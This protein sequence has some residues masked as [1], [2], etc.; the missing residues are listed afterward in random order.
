MKIKFDEQQ[1]QLDAVN[2]IVDIFDG[3]PVKV[4]NFSVGAGHILG[5]QQTELGI[6]NKLELS[7]QEILEN[8]QTIQMRNHLKKS[9]AIQDW[10]FTVEM[11]TGTGKTYVYTRSIFELNKKY[12]F[13]KFIIV[14]PSVAIREGVYK[15]FQMTADHFNELYPGQHCHYF[16]YDSSKL[17]KVREFAT[18]SDI[19]VMIINIDAFRKSFDDPEKETKAN[20][21]HRERDTMNGKKPIEFIQETNPIV[22]I[23]EPQSVDNTE[24]AKE[25]I[26]SLNPLCKLRYSAT[27]RETYNL[28]YKLDPIDAYDQRLVKK[29]EVLSVNSDD[30]YNDPYIKLI[31]VS[32]KSGYKATIEL[33]EKK[34]N[35]NVTRVRKQI[36]PNKKNNLFLLS[37]ERDLYQGY[38]VDGIDCFPGNESIEFENGKVL[39]LGGVIGGMDDNLLKRYQ[40]RETIRTHLDK[41]LKLVH[42]GIKVLSLF[43]ID[44]VAN[45]RIYNDD[46]TWSHGR[47]AQMFEEEYMNLIKHQKYHA[48]FKEDSFLTNFN[49]EDVHGGYFSQD[50]KGN[51]KDSRTTKDGSLRSNKDDESFF[52][53]IM[54]NKE[55][56]LSFEEPT[57]FIFSHSALKEGWDNPNVFQICTLVETKDTLTK[58]QKIGRGLRLPV[59]K[60][61]RRVYDENDNILTV[62]A[63]ESYEEFADSLQK[64]MED[65]TGIKFGYIEQQAFAPI[66]F[67]DENNEEQILGYKKSEKLFDYLLEKKYIDKKGKVKDS[68][69]QDLVSEDF[70]VPDEF[71]PVQQEIERVIKKSIKKLPVFNEKDKVSIGLN[72]EVLLSEDFNQLWDKI[73]YKTTYSVQLDSE[74]LMNESVSAI[75]KL[76]PFR[77]RKVKR[78]NALLKVEH[79]GVTGEGQTLRVYEALE[80]DRRLPDILRYLQEQT[81][82]KRRT[83]VDI[84]IKSERLD[85]F[86]RDPQ[87]FMEAVMKI[88][89]REKRKLI[90]DGIKYEKIGDYEYYEQS[91][92]ENEELVGYMK[93]NAVKVDD[94]K[95]VYN[96]I[97]Y[98]SDTEKTF[99]EKL[100]NDEDVKLFVKLPG[101][102]VID[103]PL[104]NYN[105]D[106]AIL[107]ENDGVEKLFFVIET[108]GSTD[109][110][111][112][113]LREDG[114]IECGRKHF[115]ALENGVKY[116]VAS[117]YEQLKENI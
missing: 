36:D 105:P 17:E 69:K 112:L 43:F 28:M 94:D 101:S 33:D 115:A 111:D 85:D 18:S 38:V 49:V 3:Q 91:L 63:N 22:I 48:L 26:T 97:K 4:S 65:E 76:A 78:E 82:L 44:K 92:F 45:Y 47:Y 55:R 35:G 108:K 57:R 24:K 93:A 68:L 107:V 14:V 20:L 51:F 89:N 31:S 70:S 21:I 83:I 71:L 5:Q 99:A 8:I 58:R 13:S 116:D 64:E 80:E 54:K 39:G 109:Q 11:E 77:A 73:K 12:G 42:K 37:G 84:L 74:R 72:K 87:A 40:I 25:A 86:K 46:G 9:N 29:I 23:D 41:E 2:S 30:D 56:L 34:K 60:D 95:S 114:K 53:L 27:H 19:E 67:K 10:N 50:K 79:S 103:T 16:I 52:E 98:D 6:G 1:Y 96:Y 90:I 88:I 81:N 32:N 62:V 113:R 15:S 104:G 66:T 117:S 61:G 100:N 59:S 106:W 7:E 75:R 110:E 102:F